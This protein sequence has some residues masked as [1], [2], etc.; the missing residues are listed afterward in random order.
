MKMKIVIL[1]AIIATFSCFTSNEN[2]FLAMDDTEDALAS[3]KTTPSSK[4]DATEVNAPTQ[5]IV[6]SI[7]KSS[8]KKSEDK[9]S[10]DKKSE[11]KK[12]D[13]K[14]AETDRKSDKVDE[15]SHGESKKTGQSKKGEHKK[16]EVLEDTKKEKKEAKA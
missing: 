1:F 9:K 10:E 11:D 14:K 12:S 16:N 3:R 8:K 15:T 7:L 13:D 6:G 5:D 4:A 2:K